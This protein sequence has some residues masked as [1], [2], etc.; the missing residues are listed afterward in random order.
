MYTKTLVKV[1]WL[2]IVNKKVLMVRSRGQELFFNVGGK[3]EPHES[4]I[5]ALIRETD[6][7]VGIKLVPITIKRIYTFVGK[8]E[9]K[10]ADKMIIMPS[11]SADFVGSLD[12]FKPGSEIEELAWMGIA[13]RHR[14]T[15][16]GRQ[17]FDWMHSNGLID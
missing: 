14:T 5:D 2:P 4:D 12:D 17:G 7:E 10:H 16:T 11:F 1:A 3:P 8:G 6:E 9:G 13:D 15:N